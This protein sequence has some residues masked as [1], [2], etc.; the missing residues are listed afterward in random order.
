MNQYEIDK[1]VGDIQD[2]LNSVNNSVDVDEK[3]EIRDS[4]FSDNG[5]LKSDQAG[6]FI[7]E[8]SRK[9]LMR[10]M[11]YSRFASYVVEAMAIGLI[12][13]GVIYPFPSLPRTLMFLAGVLLFSIFTITMLLGLQA[14]IRL[15]LQIETN[16]REIAQNKARIAEALERI[17]IE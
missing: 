11:K 1:L 6:L 14:R 10:F 9:N 15:L 2:Y 5:E 16:T 8:K 3:N 7:P 12:T 13:T 4:A 17:H